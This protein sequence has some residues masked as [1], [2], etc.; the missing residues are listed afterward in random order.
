MALAA[1]P[2]YGEGCWCVGRTRHWLIPQ[3]PGDAHSRSRL[4]LAALDSGRHAAAAAV[5]NVLGQT[6]EQTDDSVTGMRLAGKS[7]SEIPAD[8][9]ALWIRPKKTPVLKS[10][11]PTL[12]GQIERIL[13][14][15][16][17]VVPLRDV[18]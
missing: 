9:A 6:E 3:S 5:E 7:K 11:S 18:S 12:A 17:N 16:Q 1:L 14:P 15:Q 13:H 8:N 2:F 10:T 4:A